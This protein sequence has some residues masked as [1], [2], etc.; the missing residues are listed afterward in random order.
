MF[1]VTLTDKWGDAYTRNDA[2]SATLMV[3]VRLFADQLIDAGHIESHNSIVGISA[4]ALR[5]HRD[6]EW[7]NR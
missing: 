3:A 5:R 2:A 4:E 7:P 1:R 6:M